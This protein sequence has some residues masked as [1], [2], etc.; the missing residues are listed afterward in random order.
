M[1]DEA[2]RGKCL[3]HHRLCVWSGDVDFGFITYN[4]LLDS[5]WSEL[6]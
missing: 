2:S 6:S 4:K 5:D 3:H 1:R